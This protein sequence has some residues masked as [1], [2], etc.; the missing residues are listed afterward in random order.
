MLKSLTVGNLLDSLI[1]IT[2]F[3]RGEANKIFD[4]VR[5]T[6]CKVVVKNNAPTCVLLTPERYRE[7]VD[8]LEEAR[9]YSLISE[10]LKNDIGVTVSHEEMLRRCDIISEELDDIPMEYGVDFE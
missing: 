3:N 2:R 8:E 4:E 10:R 5:E 7:M 6:G 1:P 9:L